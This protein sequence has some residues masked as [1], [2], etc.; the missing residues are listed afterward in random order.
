[1]DYSA[2]AKSNAVRQVE[3][4]DWGKAVLEELLLRAAE[5][6]SDRGVADGS[7]AVSLT[8]DLTP[9]PSDGCIEIS[10]PGVVERAIITRLALP[11]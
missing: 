5:Q 4:R 10:T 9:V 2:V 1:L 8:F 7:V 6:V 3:L 11:V